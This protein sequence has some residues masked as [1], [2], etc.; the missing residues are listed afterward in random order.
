MSRRSAEGRSRGR[1]F[2]VVF[3]PPALACCASCFPP[4][5]SAL[6]T[7]GLPGGCQS[8]RPDPDGVSTFHTPESRPDWVPSL[9]RDH[10]VLSGRSDPSDRRAP[11]LP[12]ARSYRP[13]P[14]PISRSCL[15]RG[16]VKGSL[17]FTRPAFPPA[18]SSLDGT[19]TSLGTLP[20][21][22]TPQTR[23]LQSTPRRETGIEHSP[24][25]TVRPTSS[26]LLS[27]SSL[28]V[29]DLVSH[30]RA[31]HDPIPHPGAPGVVDEA[32]PAHHPVRA[33]HSR[34]PHRVG[35]RAGAVASIDGRSRS[36]W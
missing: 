22:R 12:G 24:G 14:H 10:A 18:R 11:P 1:G 15:L 23:G 4:R 21:L 31:R 17:A 2:P 5:V 30:D 19:R 33:G 13:G 6:L 26:H 36:R 7:V 9:P 27:N 32:V 34:R 25:A 3:R 35:S 20:G 29:C 28:V 16:V 8:I